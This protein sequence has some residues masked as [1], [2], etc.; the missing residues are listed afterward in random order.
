[1]SIK[2]KEQYT[3]YARIDPTVARA[4]DAC[5][6]AE[7]RRYAEIVETALRQYCA[8]YMPQKEASNDTKNNS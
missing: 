7:D 5:A 8:R 4:M 6:T 1:M 2:M 3:L